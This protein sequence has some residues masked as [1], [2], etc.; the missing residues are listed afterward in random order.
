MLRRK[1]NSEAC[2]GA[3]ELKFGTE[4]VLRRA[5]LALKS[6]GADATVRP[7]KAPPKTTKL[8]RYL[9]AHICG[10]KGAAI[11]KIFKFAQN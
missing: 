3:G 5:Y 4:T 10:G 1:L 2:R 7:H 9:Q 6:G 8:S 11:M